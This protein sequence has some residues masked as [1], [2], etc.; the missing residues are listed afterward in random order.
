MLYPMTI[1]HTPTVFRQSP[2]KS[3][4]NEKL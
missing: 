2:K 3:D 4:T 1:N